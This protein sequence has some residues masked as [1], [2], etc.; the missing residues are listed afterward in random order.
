MEMGTMAS[1]QPARQDGQDDIM[2]IARLGDI[3]GM[4]RLFETAGYDATYTDDEGITPLHV[5]PL[6]HKLDGGR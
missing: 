4:E 2:Q 1:D 3:Q 6:P 5:G